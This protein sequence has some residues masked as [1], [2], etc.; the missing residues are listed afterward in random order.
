MQFQKIE[1]YTMEYHLHF[2]RFE[3]KGF[4]NRYL[5]LEQSTELHC[6]W[7]HWQHPNI[8]LTIDFLT[9]FSQK[10]FVI[11]NKLLFCS[12]VRFAQIED[13]GPM[14]PSTNIWR[15]FLL[16][17]SKKASI[18]SQSLVFYFLKVEINSK[19]TTPKWII[20]SAN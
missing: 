17:N 8:L 20:R 1:L 14:G 10:L 11:F 12:R 9:K 6:Q 19:R 18:L 5:F 3:S 2:L 16:A 13:W 7:F 4:D 15:L